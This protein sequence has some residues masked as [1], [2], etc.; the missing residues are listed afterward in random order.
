MTLHY[1]LN[2]VQL[3][4]LHT[5]SKLSKQIYW[6]DWWGFSFFFFFWIKYPCIKLVIGWIFHNHMEHWYKLQIWVNGWGGNKAVLF[7]Y[8]YVQL[9]SDMLP[10]SLISPIFIYKSLVEPSQLYYKNTCPSS[11]TGIEPGILWWWN[12]LLS[13]LARLHPVLCTHQCL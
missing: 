12:K 8:R 7:N 1:F 13:H 5:I 3:K 10:Y 4:W 11:H 9:I 6:V 2:V